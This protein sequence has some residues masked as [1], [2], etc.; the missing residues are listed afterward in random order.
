MAENN[1]LQPSMVK[2]VFLKQK[3]INNNQSLSLLNSYDVCMAVSR[4][5]GQ[6]NVDGVQNINGIWQIY[7][8][9]KESRVNLLVRGT[10]TLMG[11]QVHLFDKNPTLVKDPSE[12]LE[13]FTI[14]DLPLSVSNNEIDAFLA[15]KG[16]VPIS[17]IKYTR[18]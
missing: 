6:G 3:A 10:L 13:G 11:R 1:L 16:L 2:A 5:V 15:S 9:N 14:N 17:S 8:L 4:I 7:L 18:G 12:S